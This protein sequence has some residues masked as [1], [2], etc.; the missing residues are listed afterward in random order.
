[1]LTAPIVV[2]DS[3]EA[4]DLLKQSVVSS[5]MLEHAPTLRQAATLV[6]PDTA[7]VIC[8]CHFD[9][10]RMYELL[11]HLKARPELQ[12]VPFMAIRAMEG[13]LD[14]TLYESVK[15]AVRALGGDSFVDLFRWQRRYGDAEAAHRLTQRIEALAGAP[16]TGSV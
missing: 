3:Q 4:F 9:D 15:T 11:R 10:G 8:G 6:T 5:F 2:A 7:L 12:G 14:D 1:M 13:E 16:Q